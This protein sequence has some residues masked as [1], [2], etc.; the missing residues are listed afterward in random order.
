MQKKLTYKWSL[1]PASI[2]FFIIALLLL[3]VFFRLVNLDQKVYWLDETFTSLRV[4]GYTEQELVQ[5]VSQQI[6]SIKD[7]QKYQH[8]APEKSVID[9]IKGLA[10]EEAQLPPLY[11]IMSRFWVQIWGDSV[12]AIR[13]LPALINLLAFPASTGCA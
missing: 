10:L 1:P 2:R 13:S 9:T 11:F 7:L 8:L 5:Q 6:T 12:A 3:G 4:S